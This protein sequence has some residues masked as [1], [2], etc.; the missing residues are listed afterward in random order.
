MPKV[1]FLQP[2]GTERAVEASCGSSLMQAAVS[3]E[4]EGI[5]GECGGGMACATCHVFVDPGWFDRVGPPHGSEN[6]MLQCAATE[7]TETSRLGCQIVL[8][9]ELDGLVV[10]IP[11]RQN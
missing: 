8:R 7:P 10:R 4:V 9:D 3:N 6:D 1:S 5:L 11:E 2:D